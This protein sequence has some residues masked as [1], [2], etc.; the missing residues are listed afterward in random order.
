MVLNKILLEMTITKQVAVTTKMISRRVTENDL[1]KHG[2]TMC[3]STQQGVGTI[4]YEKYKS[5]RKVT[6]K[7]A[8]VLAI[9][10]HI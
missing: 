5:A 1:N 3:S 9:Y 10:K 7:S 8:S 2:G 4:N 6:Y